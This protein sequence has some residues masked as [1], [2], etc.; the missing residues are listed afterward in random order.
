MLIKHAGDWQIALLQVAHEIN[1]TLNLH[2]TKEK[3]AQSIT[4]L[5][6]QY[7]FHDQALLSNAENWSKIEANLGQVLTPEQRAFF[8]TK[9]EDL[10]NFNRESDASTAAFSARISD[11]NNSLKRFRKELHELIIRVSDMLK[12]LPE[13][14]IDNTQSEI[15]RQ[16]LYFDSDIGS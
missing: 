8:I 6:V 4:T 2:M 1:S 9:L 11:M 7:S 15:N 10:N 12:Q 16:D 14:R 13:Y 3:V 5:L